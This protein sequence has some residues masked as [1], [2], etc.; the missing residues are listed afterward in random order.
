MCLDQQAAWLFKLK[1]K[2]GADTAEVTVCIHTP[3]A[4]CTSIPT[5]SQ[6]GI[7]GMAVAMFSAVLYLRRRRSFTNLA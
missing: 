7:A 4:D 6:W 3:L 5:L 2:E 1:A